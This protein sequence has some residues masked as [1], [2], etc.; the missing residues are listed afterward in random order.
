MSAT[1]SIPEEVLLLTLDDET[2]RPLGVPAQA[3]A[4]ALAG[5]AL[6]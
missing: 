6:M 3:V 5:A 4:L 2:G 1:L